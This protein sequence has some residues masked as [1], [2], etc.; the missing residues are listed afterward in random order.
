MAAK[1]MEGKI[2]RKQ[3]QRWRKKGVDGGGGGRR[4]EQWG[5]H[6]KE[7]LLFVSWLLGPLISSPPYMR[8]SIH[9]AHPCFDSPAQTIVVTRQDAALTDGSGGSGGIPVGPHPPPPTSTPSVSEDLDRLPAL[10][11]A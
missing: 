5:G 4:K 11:S 2:H 6:L 3:I 9:H 1:E 8:L 10:Y 7:V